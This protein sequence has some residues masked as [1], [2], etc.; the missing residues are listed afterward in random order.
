LTLPRDGPTLTTIG[1]PE[2]HCIIEVPVTPTGIE[3]F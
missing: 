1:P 2:R 3:P